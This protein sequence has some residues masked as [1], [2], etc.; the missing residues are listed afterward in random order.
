M[1]YGLL[2]WEHQDI[3]QQIYSGKIRSST[4]NLRD[5]RSKLNYI[6]HLYYNNNELCNNTWRDAYSWIKCEINANNN[7]IYEENIYQAD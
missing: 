6:Q 3:H 5:F 7:G 2:S 4:L 1:Q